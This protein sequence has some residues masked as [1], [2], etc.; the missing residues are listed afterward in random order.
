MLSAG[1]FVSTRYAVGLHCVCFTGTT[2]FSRKCG[3]Q[4]KSPALRRHPQH[5]AGGP[6]F[7]ELSAYCTVRFVLPN[8]Q[9]TISD[10]ALVGLRVG[11]SG[12]YRHGDTRGIG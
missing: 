3:L 8:D 6:F 4:T 2:L 1:N 7:G 11:G 9:R 10:V 12:L 5:G